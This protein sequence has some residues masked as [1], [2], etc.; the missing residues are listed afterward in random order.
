MSCMVQVVGSVE[1]KSMGG[2]FWCPLYVK[3]I[4]H[5]SRIC[6]HFMTT[7]ILFVLESPA[8]G[9]QNCE[10]WISHFTQDAMCQKQEGTPDAKPLSWK[11]SSSAYVH[12]RGVVKSLNGLATQ[13]KLRWGFKP[14][15]CRNL[16]CTFWRM[17]CP[18]FGWNLLYAH[19][20]PPTVGSWWSQR[21]IMAACHCYVWWRCQSDTL[22]VTP[23]S[24]WLHLLSCY[25]QIAAVEIYLQF[26][27]ILCK[28]CHSFIS[29]WLL[30][31]LANLMIE[32]SHCFQECDRNLGQ[33]CY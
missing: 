32:S 13:R 21:V 15:L 18:D 4:L 26:I 27:D 20:H 17:V 33:R 24:L 14:V 30:I 2:H 10:L 1:T 31:V 5:G 12:L 3:C 23:I 8:T 16:W 6:C 19:L 9:C 28:T 25:I 11:I 7:Q 22:H 29:F